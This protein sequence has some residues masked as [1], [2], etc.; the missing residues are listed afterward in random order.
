EDDGRGLDIDRVRRRAAM[1]GIEV[2]DWDDPSEVARVLCAPDFSTRDEATQ[3]SGRG[4]GLGLVADAVA[5]QRGRLEMGPAAGGGFRVVASLPLEF[6]SVG[7]LLLR[8]PS[9]TLAISV[10]PSRSFLPAHLARR[11]PDGLLLV[12]SP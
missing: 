12:S 9:L 7:G 2:A 1:R 3:L 8:S 5:R 6:A 10:S 11:S 4:L